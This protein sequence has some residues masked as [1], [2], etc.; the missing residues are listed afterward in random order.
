MRDWGFSIRPRLQ[1]LSNEEVE[2]F[3]GRAMDVLERIGVRVLHREALELLQEAGAFVADDSVVRIRPTLVEEAIHSVPKRLVIYDRE[4]VPAMELGGGNTGGQNTYYGTGSDLL[5]MYDPYSG[6]LRLTVG[7]DIANMARVVDYLPNMDFLMSYGIPSDCPLEK[8]HQTGFVQMVQNSIKP[9]IFTSDNGEISREIIQM[10]AMVVG[11]TEKLQEKPF[12]LNYSQPTSPLQHS[13]NAFAK[14][15][16]CA[17]LG[18]PVVY[19]PGMIPG[20]TAPTTIAGAIT[21]S[22]AESFS[23][24]TVHQLKRKGAPIVL[25]GAHGCMDMRTSINVYAAP[26]RLM[27][28]A[29]LGAVCQHFGIPTWGFGGC[30]DAISL[31]EQ[32]GMEFGMMSLWASLC[33]INLAHDVAYLGSGMIGDLRAIVLNDEANAYVRHLVCRGV[34]VDSEHVAME[35][36]ERVGPGGNFMMDQHTF[37]HFRTELWRPGLSNRENIKSW[38]D[39]GEKTMKDVL[40]QKVRGILEKHKPKSLSLKMTNELGKMLES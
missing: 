13:E 1:V 12:I 2:Y 24:L 25:C 35:V 32:A 26:E 14:M 36:I 16:A 23:A 3:Y 18:I 29:A 28:Q 8:V 39:K 22:L 17:E 11:G 21:Q 19:P 40:D 33:G 15:F 34:N 27:T 31:D 20:A 9:I 7:Q 4:G 38:K 10:A 37:D 6:E 5:H 30:T